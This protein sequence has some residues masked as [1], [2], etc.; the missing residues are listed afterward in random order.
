MLRNRALLCMFGLIVSAGIQA[1]TPIHFMNIPVAENLPNRLMEF[2]TG[3]NFQNFFLAAETPAGGMGLIP[4]IP[5]PF[6]LAF[7][8]NM[9]NLG[10]G[11][12]AFGV[13]RITFNT[14]VLV[15]DDNFTPCY[16]GLE[17]VSVDLGNHFRIGI[18]P[19]VVTSI[20]V[21]AAAAKMY[22]SQR[23][24]K[25]TYSLG[26]QGGAL[27]C[28]PDNYWFGVLFGGIGWEIVRDRLM[29]SLEGSTQFTD[30]HRASANLILD[31]WILQIG[32]GVSVTSVGGVSTFSYQAVLRI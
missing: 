1:Q 31:L 19:M 5:F 25:F 28:I 18:E 27:L 2:E 24:G 15:N 30:R 7:H 29:V 16:G 22:C 20:D 8:V 17:F 3:V 9:V 14:A 4:F 12:A 13:E 26:I 32:G 6:Y 10:D 11:N 21:N 23:L